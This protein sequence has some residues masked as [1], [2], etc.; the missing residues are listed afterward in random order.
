MILRFNND[1]HK[2]FNWSLY[3]YSFFSHQQMLRCNKNSLH[4][5]W[6]TCKSRSQFNS[7]FVLQKM[8]RSYVLYKFCF[9]IITM[10]EQYRQNG[11]SWSVFTNHVRHIHV[12]ILV[13]LTVFEIARRMSY[14]SLMMNSNEQ[15]HVGRCKFRSEGRDRV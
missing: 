7:I 13:L 11:R 3:N 15:L 5:P 1:I 4:I 9:M 12:I 14:S 6:Y 10:I 2:F 8:R